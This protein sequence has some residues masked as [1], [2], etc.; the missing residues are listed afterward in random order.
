MR[1]SS[2][3][4]FRSHLACVAALAIVL[5]TSAAMAARA[6]PASAFVRVN[7]IGYTL[8]GSKT[9][10]LMASGAE[11]GGTFAVKS[12]STNVM[13]G[14]VGV[15]LG[16]WSA[17]FPF[18]YAL[19]LSGLT[20]AG[21]YTI[22]VTGP[23]PATSPSFRVDSGQLLYAQAL[24]NSLSFY[25]VQRDGASYVPSALRA[26]PAHLNDQAAMTYLTPN[27]NS[28]SGRFSGDLSRS[29]SRRTRRAVGS[30][31]VTI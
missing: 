15:N 9:A 12:G 8:A 16:S 17:S 27:Y 29:G 20:T 7:Q 19:D 21:T 31:Q 18:V 23:V 22:S 14:P 25:Q 3:R 4:R 30:T 6:A 1:P 5:N 10:Y 2:R 28:G 13:S 26:A 24:A 11:T